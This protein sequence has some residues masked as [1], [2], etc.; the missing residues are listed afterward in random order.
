MSSADLMVE[1]VASYLKKNPVD[2]KMANLYKTGQNDINQINI[3]FD[4]RQICQSKQTKS[5]WGSECD[6]DVE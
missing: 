2:V 1:H 4:F 5:Y 3:P 6:F